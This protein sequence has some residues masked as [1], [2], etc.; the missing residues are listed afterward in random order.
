MWL[1]YP[2]ATRVVLPYDDFLN[3]VGPN[4]TWTNATTIDVACDFVA[5]GHSQPFYLEIG[6]DDTHHHWWDR[7]LP[8]SE[9][10]FGP[11]DQRGQRSLPGHPDLPE[12]RGET[13]LFRNAVRYMD[14]RVGQLLAAID[15]AGLRESTLVIVTTDHGPGLPDMKCHLNEDGLGVFM[16]MRGPGIPVGREVDALVS[17]MDL[18]PTICGALGGVAPAPVAG[19]DLGPVLRG[20]VTE[21]RQQVFSE[22]TYHG[23]AKALRGVR[24]HEH[25]YVRAL[26]RSHRCRHGYRWRG[27]C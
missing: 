27:H 23:M 19:Y 16:M 22:Q 8:D 14:H 12:T 21:V 15:S 17:H 13:A 5:A 6:L 7:I 4:A 3:H 24:T 11:I 25:S 20:E 9:A 1:A 26:L 2:G 10:L 18:F